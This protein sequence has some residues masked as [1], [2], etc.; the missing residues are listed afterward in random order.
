MAGIVAGTVTP[1]ARRSG[2]RCGWRAETRHHTGNPTSAMA[3]GEVESLLAGAAAPCREGARSADRAL[4][5]KTKF[6]AGVPS[7]LSGSRRLRDRI[8]NHIGGVPD[9]L[10]RPLLA[11]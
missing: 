4:K 5:A 8:R 1:S 3:R 2:L 9:P 7:P 6:P 10:L 11:P